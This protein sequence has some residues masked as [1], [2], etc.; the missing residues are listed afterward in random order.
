MERRLKTLEEERSIIKS[1]FNIQINSLMEE[2]E[3]LKQH[4]SRK[5]TLPI[6]RSYLNLGYEEAPSEEYDPAKSVERNPD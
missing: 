4:L 1:N 3:V 2:K 5:H 6:L